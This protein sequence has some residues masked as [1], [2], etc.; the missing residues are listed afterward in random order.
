[1]QPGDL[2]RFT[3]DFHALGAEHFRGCTFMILEVAER[4]KIFP[5]E[6]I[7]PGTMD[8]YILVGGKVEGPWGYPWVAQNSE[9]ISEAG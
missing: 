4:R 5:D 9:A 8:A 6:T 3:D 2:R 7:A 1:M